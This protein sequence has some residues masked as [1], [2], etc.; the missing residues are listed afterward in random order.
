VHDVKAIA[1]RKTG[2]FLA[3]LAVITIAGL[4]AAQPSEGPAGAMGV[5]PPLG[6][7]TPDGTLQMTPPAGWE[8]NPRLSE[9]NG[10]IA[11]LHPSGMQKDQALPA[12][13]LV[14]RRNRDPKVPFSLVVRACISEGEVFDYFPADS[15]TMTTADGR[16]LA[17]YRFNLGKDGS[18]RG[19]ALLEIPT[20]TL[21]FRYEAVSTELWKQQQGAFE[22]MLRSIRFLP[23][24]K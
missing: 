7:T 20:G 9:D 4:A 23:T 5:R 21:L 13:L 3:V 1:A 22:A 2:S 19:L 17:A 12:W 8:T 16:S 24:A 15:T 10:V 18:E 14:D 11:F 6:W